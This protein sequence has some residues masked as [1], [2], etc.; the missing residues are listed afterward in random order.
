MWNSYLMHYLMNKFFAQ[1]S[2][3][4]YIFA[5]EIEEPVAADVF[6]V[7][8]CVGYAIRHI[9]IIRICNQFCCQN[10]IF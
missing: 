5:E 9:F 2:G 4:I 7:V 10:N 1:W 3:I 8:R 6:V